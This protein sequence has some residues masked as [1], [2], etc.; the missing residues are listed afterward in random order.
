M[1]YKQI[2]TRTLSEQ[3]FLLNTESPR[4]HTISPNKNIMQTYVVNPIWCNSSIPYISRCFYKS[5]EKR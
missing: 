1:K 5:E 2:D 4:K 3:F